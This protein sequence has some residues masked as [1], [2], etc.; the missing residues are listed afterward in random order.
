MSA[1]N[2]IAVEAF[3]ARRIGFLG[4]AEIVAGVLDALGAPPADTLEAVLDLDERGR[5]AARDACSSLSLSA[6]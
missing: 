2:E 3:L 1:A 4:I 6:A 5:R